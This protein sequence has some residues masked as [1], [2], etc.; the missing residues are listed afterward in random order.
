MY[1]EWRDRD[2]SVRAQGARKFV[3]RISEDFR[4]EIAYSI[5][6]STIYE[7]ELLTTWHPND[8]MRVF[9]AKGTTQRVVQVLRQ[10]L[11][12]D[13][14][15]CALNF[16]SYKNPGGRFFDGSKAQEEALC[17]SSTLYPVLE[18][19]QD[20]YYDINKRNLNRGMYKH[21][22]IYSHDITFCDYARN[23]SFSAD[24]LTCAAPNFSVALKYN[25]F[26][27]EENVE[28]LIQRIKFMYGILANESVDTFVSG[29]WGCGVFKQNPYTVARL[30]SSLALRANPVKNLVFAVPATDRD[31]VNYDAFRDTLERCAPDFI[32]I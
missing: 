12:A 26:T 20:D 3:D 15:L 1:P 23:Q 19:F 21:R 13:V 8:S 24:I 27:V 5:K 4:D 14:S 22:A 18:S 17:A 7:P 6:N 25:N 9:L 30:M 2:K 28:I 31:S 29:A 16:A 11:G 10:Q 32:V